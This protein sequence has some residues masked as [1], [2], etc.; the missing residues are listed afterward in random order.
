MRLV[1]PILPQPPEGIDICVHDDVARGYTDGNYEIVWSR[2]LPT[3]AVAVK[4]IA[5]TWCWIVNAP[6][7]ILD[8]D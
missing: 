3:N 6:D 7:N 5:E 1:I 4:R 2:E 8:S